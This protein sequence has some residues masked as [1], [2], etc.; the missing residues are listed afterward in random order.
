LAG[1]LF[2]QLLFA[3]DA[4]TASVVGGLEGLSGAVDHIGF[5]LIRI[6][7]RQESIKAPL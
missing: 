3:A 1:L 5:D 2:G 6:A 7:L 4:G